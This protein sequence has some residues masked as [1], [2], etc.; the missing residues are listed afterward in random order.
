MSEP[1]FLEDSVSLF[2][3]EEREPARAQTLETEEKRIRESLLSGRREAAFR[4]WLS[5]ACVNAT[6]KVRAELLEKL[7]EGKK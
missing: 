1:V 2:R 7:V 6:V 3:V 4:R 5:H